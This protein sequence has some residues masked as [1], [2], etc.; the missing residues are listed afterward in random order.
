[1]Q[2]N[3]PA[4]W[5]QMLDY[6]PICFVKMINKSTIVPGELAPSVN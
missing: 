1:M 6:E 4:S 3:S 5:F 2:S